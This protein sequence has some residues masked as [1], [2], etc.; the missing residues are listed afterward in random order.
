MRG[1]GFCLLLCLLFGNIVHA[2]AQT[3]D[4]FDKVVANFRKM[5]VLSESGANETEQ[6]A[7][8]STVVGKILFHENREYLNTLEESLF[9]DITG[10]TDA[11]GSKLFSER[12]S[13]DN[14]LWDA[15]KLAFL[16]MIESLLSRLENEAIAGKIG[17]HVF[18]EL[19]KDRIT[20]NRIQQRYNK[21]LGAVF[22]KFS[23]RAIQDRRQQWNEYVR[24]LSSKLNKASI[25]KEYKHL[26]LLPSSRGDKDAKTNREVFGNAL[27]EK[28]LVLTFDDGPHPRYSQKILKTLNEYNIQ[29]IFFHVGKNLGTIDKNG[30]VKLTPH[31]K[32]SQQLLDSGGVLANHSYSHPVLPKLSAE[33]LATEIKTTNQLIKEMSGNQPALFRAPYGAR[34]ETILAKIKSMNLYSV[35]WNIDSKDWADPVPKSIAKRVLDEVE[36]QKQGIILFHDIQ[37]QTVEAL[38]LVLAELNKRGYKFA[39]WDGSGF[40]VDDK[41]TVVA[42]N[43]TAS[44]LYRESWAVVIGID[45]YQHWPKLSY[46]AN[47]ARGIKELLIKRF[48]FKEENIFSLYNEQATRANILSLLNDKL[49]N[50]KLIKKN[51]RVIIFYAGHGATRQLYSGRDLGYIIPVDAKAKDFFGQSISMTS[52]NDISEGIPAKHLFMIMDSCYSGLALTRSGSKADSRN[53]IQENNKRTARQMLTAGGADQEVADGGP[54]GHSVFTWSLIQA[55]EGKGDMNKDG[56]ITAS[57]LASYISPIVSSIS[58][59]TPAFGNLVGSQGGDVVFELET[60]PEHLNN[61]S[62]QLDEQEAQ[63]NKKL[64]ELKRQIELKRQRNLEKKKELQE[65]KKLLAKI[66]AGEQATEQPEATA[67]E[68]NEEG[69]KLYRQKKYQASLDKFIQASN[70][71]PT[72]V[73]AVNNSGF[74][75]YRLKDYKNAVVWLEKTVALDRKRAVAWLNLGDCYFEVGDF[76]SAEAAYRMHLKLSPNSKARNKVLQKLTEMV[77]K[78]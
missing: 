40:V 33:E 20:L 38:P 66:E 26:S 47:D 19:K 67:S 64:D 70:T 7:Q 75:Y 63:I 37:S 41:K 68:L 10:T 78:K 4:L 23:T 18:T 21:E 62:A 13:A 65:A 61:L 31:A 22:A 53:F 76:N 28:T 77:T 44:S 43:N 58:L 6:D 73:E 35:M 15:D 46:A 51:D 2:S 57:E 56:F 49:G 25:L 8:L 32:I 42:N 30:K 1:K 74:L 50:N 34:N 16:S 60:K 52:I 71:D 36:K 9:T 72:F 5:I 48:K 24:F 69:L 17:K 12:L 55:L 39:R 54:H 14:G 3:A 59:Q 45:E 27:P 11:K 29:P